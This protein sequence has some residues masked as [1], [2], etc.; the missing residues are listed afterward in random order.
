MT[1]E[2]IWIAALAILL[3]GCNR[4]A[5]RQFYQQKMAS[6]I[7]V[8]EDQLYDA[9]YHN[10]VLADELERCRVRADT[11]HRQSAPNQSAPNQSAP[12]QSAPNQSALPPKSSAIESIP[13]PI[14]DSAPNRIEPEQVNPAP[15]ERGRIDDGLQFDEDELELPPMESGEV[16]EPERLEIPQPEM[17]FGPEPLPAPGLPQPPSEQD[18]TIPP[19]EPGEV[20]PPPANGGDPGSDRPGRIVLPDSVSAS[21]VMPQS[22]KV[23]P[24]LSSGITDDGQ[25]QQMTIMVNVIDSQ[26]RTVDLDKFEIDAELSLV[27]IDPARPATE[28]K[29][30]RWDF[31]GPQL[32]ELVTRAPISGLQIPVKWQGDRPQ[33]SEVVV[34][35]RL[36]GD[37]DE[38]RCEAALE[39]E[40]KSSIAEWT[41]RAD[42]QKR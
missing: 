17:E 8:L 9:D 35:A 33:G 34:H 11:G 40:K 39:V 38:L 25:T 5:Q 37:E 19:I 42:E 30:G 22:I 14:P 16:V 2:T 23:H 24:G 28:A 27:L 6:E 18:T 32:L 12:N 15:I 3:L 4:G 31:T 13:E 21:S 1:A 36:R 41:P 7:R 29:L 20:L 26:G 10:R